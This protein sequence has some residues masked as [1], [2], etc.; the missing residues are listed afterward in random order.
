MTEVDHLPSYLFF[1]S[2]FLPP[3]DDQ[4]HCTALHSTLLSL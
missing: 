4:L 2:F 1:L 3:F